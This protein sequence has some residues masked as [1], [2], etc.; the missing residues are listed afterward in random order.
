MSDCYV[1][2]TLPPGADIRRLEASARTLLAAVQSATG[3][4][5][6]LQRRIGAQETWMEVYEQVSDTEG[7]SRL[8]GELANWHNL[9]QPRH[10]EW[11]EDV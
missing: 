9:P 11:F 6:R 7:F 4:A 8:L 10:L 3:V 1:Y 5:G 2:Y